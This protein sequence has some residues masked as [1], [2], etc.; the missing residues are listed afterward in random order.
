MTEIRTA[1]LLDY[2]KLRYCVN[3]LELKKKE[4]TYS[5]FYCHNILLLLHK[6]KTKDCYKVTNQH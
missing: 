4:L 2:C 6:S 3:F 1:I 5:L